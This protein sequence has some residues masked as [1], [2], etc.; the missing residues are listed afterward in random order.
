M[1]EQQQRVADGAGF[2]RGDDARLDVQGFGV[3]HPSEL[4][5][6]DVQLE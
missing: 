3:R 6:V 5:E 2:A 4:E 1:L